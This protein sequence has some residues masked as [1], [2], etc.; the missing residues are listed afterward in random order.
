[1]GKR[2]KLP[3]VVKRVFKAPRW[4]YDEWQ[5][6]SE[7]R[8]E[9]ILL[10][11]IDNDSVYR[12]EFATD[13]FVKRKDVKEN[14]VYIFSIKRTESQT[15]F[16]CIGGPNDGKPGVIGTEGYIWYNCAQNHR[17]PKKD[18]PTAVLVYHTLLPK[19]S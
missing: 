16:P 10:Q 7:H 17:G 18:F 13:V 19:P 6:H 15:K 9:N 1:M 2:I 11:E 8:V 12:K 4:Y 5:N 14:W 3:P